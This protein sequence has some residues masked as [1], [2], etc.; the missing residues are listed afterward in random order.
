M[1]ARFELPS[2]V[3]ESYDSESLIEA[4]THDKKAR[5]D[6]T[7]VLAGNGGFSVV[8]GIEIARVRDALTR[9]RGES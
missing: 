7:F 8:P 4:M 6:L 9:F 1:L 5:H 2:R 3:P